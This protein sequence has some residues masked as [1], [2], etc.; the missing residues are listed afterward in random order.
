M[1]HKSSQNLMNLA[2]RIKRMDN[3]IK[4]VAAKQ[5]ARVIGMDIYVQDTEPVAPNCVW[6]DTRGIDLITE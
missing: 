3:R 1:T 4:N 5:E 2:A 6:I